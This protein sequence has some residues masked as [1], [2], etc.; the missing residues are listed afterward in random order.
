MT[1]LPVSVHCFR[2]PDGKVTN[3]QQISPLSFSVAFCKESSE[4]ARGVCCPR[5][6]TFPECLEKMWMPWLGWKIPI[7]VWLEPCTISQLTW[8]R[9]SFPVR[10]Q[11]KIMS[12][13]SSLR[14]IDILLLE[15]PV[16]T[17]KATG[18]WCHLV[19]LEL[20]N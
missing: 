12:S 8:V 20:E 13:P 10:T 9:L 2:M 19:G 1:S 16:E 6:F 15:M 4:D 5:I 18:L 14:L 7:L 3:W 17:K 11:V